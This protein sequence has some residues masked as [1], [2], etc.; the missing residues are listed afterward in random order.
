[1]PPSV[2]LKYLLSIDTECMTSEHRG[3]P[4]NIAYRHFV[5]RF[6]YRSYHHPYLIDAVFPANF[7]LKSF[8]F[9]L[10]SSANISSNKLLMSSAGKQKHYNCKSTYFLALS[11]I[12]HSSSPTALQVTTTFLP[13]SSDSQLPLSFGF[14]GKHPLEHGS[15]AAGEPER[16]SQ[17][18]PLN[19]SPSSP[20]HPFAH[21]QIKIHDTG[22]QSTLAKLWDPS[23]WEV[24]NLY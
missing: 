14:H 2:L 22:V 21:M 17:I 8:I 7:F 1:M 20:A 18:H 16:L 9:I 12:Q 13:G 24:K 4:S 11:P 10:P 19:A 3:N 23:M 15:P 5:S 6:Y